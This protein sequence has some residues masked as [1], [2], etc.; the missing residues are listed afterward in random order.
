[1]ARTEGTLTEQQYAAIAEVTG[2]YARKVRSGHPMR[3]VRSKAEAEGRKGLRGRPGNDWKIIYDSED[4]ARRAADEIAAITGGATQSAYRCERSRSG[5]YHLT[6]P[7]SAFRTM[8]GMTVDA[9]REKILSV[10]TPVGELGVD[11]EQL[12][13]AAIRLGV[14]RDRMEAQMFI[15]AM[16]SAG[17][18]TRSGG[19]PGRV[20][21]AGVVPASS[22]GAAG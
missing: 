3:C 7:D 9:N 20:F 6:S 10:T 1:M 18:L 14:G 17:L 5:H 19:K 8:L 11:Y 21:T 12:V 16:L 13:T 22:T 2:R 15:G 4:D